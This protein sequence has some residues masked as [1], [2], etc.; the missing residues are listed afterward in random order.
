[1]DNLK[2]GFYYSKYKYMFSFQL[3]LYFP[4]L[5]EIWKPNRNEYPSIL[6]LY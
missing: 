5:I 2:G 6:V 3:Q 1:M 4:C